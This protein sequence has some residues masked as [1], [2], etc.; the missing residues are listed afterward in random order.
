MMITKSGSEGISMKNVRQVHIMEPYWNRI[1]LDQVIGRAVRAESHIDLPKNERFVDVFQYLMKFTKE[2]L[3]DNFTLRKLDHSLTTDQ[4]IDNIATKKMKIISKLQ[5]L[6]KEAS[7]DC[8][9]HNDPNF[10]CFTL[11]INF[12]DKDLIIKSNIK[13]EDENSNVDKLEI[14]K[15]IQFRKVLIYDIPFLIE[16]QSTELFDYNLWKN[17][18]IIKSIGFLEKKNDK[19]YILTIIKKYYN[20]YLKNVHIS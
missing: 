4:V 20:K 7:V 11:P 5:T 8:F 18:N 15:K 9:I 14:S 19:L 3:D 2:Q 16:Y 10:E 12:K 1:R 6:M 17:N 13:D